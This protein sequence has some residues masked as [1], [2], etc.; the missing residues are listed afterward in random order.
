MVFGS[1]HISCKAYDGG[2]N[3]RSNDDKY[4]IC[5]EIKLT[6]NNWVG[7][8]CMGGARPGSLD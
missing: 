3:L 2:L 4:G 5:V 7:S 6:S 1:V 8:G